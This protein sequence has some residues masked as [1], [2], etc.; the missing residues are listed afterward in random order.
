MRCKK[1]TLSV[2]KTRSDA[3]RN[4]RLYCKKNNTFD[5]IFFNNLKKDLFWEKK[6]QKTPNL[7]VKILHKQQRKSAKLFEY[8]IYMDPT[9]CQALRSTVETALGDPHSC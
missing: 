1:V 5:E 3:D 4:S 6:I 2:L 8:L 7:Q 9:G